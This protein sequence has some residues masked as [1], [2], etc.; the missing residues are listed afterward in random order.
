MKASNRSGSDQEKKTAYIVLVETTA[1]QTNQA[2]RVM[3]RQGAKSTMPPEDFEE[4]P[5]STDMNYKQDYAV[6]GTRTDHV[7]VPL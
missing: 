2:S 5:T 6:A 1:G 3:G 7:D 4:E